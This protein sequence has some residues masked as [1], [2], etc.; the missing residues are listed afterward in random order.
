MHVV[1]SS[2]I[3]RVTLLIGQFSRLAQSG[4]KGANQVRRDRREC[5]AR[6]LESSN[7]HTDGAEMKNYQNLRAYVLAVLCVALTTG[8]RAAD[9]NEK[10]TVG[11]KSVAGAPMKA[12][13]ATGLI[14]MPVKNQNDEKLGEIEDLVVDLQ[15]GKVSY[16]VLD[17]GGVLKDKLFAVPLSAFTSSADHSYLILHADKSKMETAQGFDKNSWPSVSNPSWGAD[18]FWQNRQGIDQITPGTPTDPTKDRQNPLR[19]TDK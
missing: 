1:F 15:S 14:G 2:P 12:N 10:A 18:T 5:A 19:P 9:E 6:F 11:Y 17:A 16:A 3:L 13:K 8:V 4:L 7:K